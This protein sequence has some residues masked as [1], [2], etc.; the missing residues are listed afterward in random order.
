MQKDGL[1]LLLSR[2]LPQEEQPHQHPCTAHVDLK[3]LEA[4]FPPFPHPR[5]FLISASC[6]CGQDAFSQDEIIALRL[7]N[8]RLKNQCRAYQ[9]ELDDLRLAGGKGGSVDP[10]GYI[11]RAK[12][13]ESELRHA[14]DAIAALK[15][16]RKR[17]KTEKFDLLNQ[18][19]Q[20][21][22]TLEEKE[23]GVRDFIRNYEHRMK[24]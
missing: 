3:A 13:A 14:K 20:L 19:K 15:T 18:M 8:E 22:S 17:L 21:Y 24:V 5:P 23:K 12:D 9:R 2:S 1:A 7:E 10:T 4:I 16:D 6:S 11:Q